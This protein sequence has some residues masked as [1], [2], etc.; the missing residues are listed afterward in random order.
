MPGL[1]PGR[2][3]TAAPA[4]FF[5]FGGWMMESPWEGIPGMP[6]GEGAAMMVR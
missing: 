4:R 5:L 6:E 1:T 2:E 3:L